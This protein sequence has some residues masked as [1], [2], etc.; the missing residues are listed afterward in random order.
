MVA[1]LQTETEV[2]LFIDCSQDVAYANIGINL[3]NTET[4]VSDFSG[5]SASSP[6][7][8][9]GPN[10]NEQLCTNATQEELG[11]ELGNSISTAS[12]VI[13]PS[14]DN[15]NGFIDTVSF[16]WLTGSP[17]VSGTPPDDL[18]IL[19][20]RGK[21]GPGGDL[22]CLAGTEDNK[23]G[24][25]RL[26]DFVVGSNPLSK[27][28]FSTF[29][30]Q[31]TGEEPGLA[32]LEGPPGAPP[33]ED[34]QVVFQVNPP[35]NPLITLQLRPVEDSETHYELSIKVDTAN[36]GLQKVARIAFGLTASAA[37]GQ[38]DMSFGGCQATPVP[39]A[40][41]D[42]LR[43]CEGSDPQLLTSR[44]DE[45]TE[46]E[47]DGSFV[48]ATYTVGPDAP[49]D[50]SGSSRLPNT[51]YVAVDSGFFEGTDAVL[52]AAGG[53]QW[54]GVVV[55]SEAADP[56]Q[57]TFQGT[58]EL[59][60]YDEPPPDG[61]AVVSAVADQFTEQNVTLSNT[62]ATSSDTDGDGDPDDL[63]NCVR[64]ENPQQENT[65]GVG[66][67]TSEA[68][69][70][71]I[72]DACQCADPGRDGVADN[73]SADVPEGT[74]F[75]PQDDVLNCQKAL[76]GQGLDP[77]ESSDFCKVTTTGGDFSII[78]VLVLEAETAVPESSGLGDPKTGSLQSCGAAEGQL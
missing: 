49:E 50:L 72:G 1:A 30:P 53:D 37:V 15:P 73:G 13:G 36:V 8:N 78:D 33:V 39:D 4:T 51:L 32:Q 76:S 63:D 60:G 61:N 56:P 43:G 48:V 20:L 11:G 38:A 26:Q 41:L 65:G 62:S 70:D 17:S 21:G 5:C 59:P 29:D 3:S 19:Q 9:A 10:P 6:N 57:I 12:S 16:P 42:S 67:V 47:T 7:P 28:G 69:F 23:L 64:V 46:F 22:I 44:A 27:A 66:F 24:V 75:T 25:L 14:T 35:G 52:N 34:E 40:P 68:N 2:E 18:V 54:L 45:M 55:F 58:E 77:S 71:K 74:S 31:V